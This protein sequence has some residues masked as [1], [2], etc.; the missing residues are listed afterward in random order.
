M[1]AINC[2]FSEL[3]TRLMKLQKQKFA[4]WPIV[5]MICMLSGSASDA[6][7]LMPDQPA[8][9][10]PVLIEEQYQQGHYAAAAQSARAY[11]A[12]PAQD[13]FKPLPAD[14]DK[15]N[16]Y[17]ALSLLKTDAP[18]CAEYARDVI[19]NTQNVAYSQRIAHSLAQ[20]YFMHDDLANAIPLYEASGI[21]NLDNKEIA[22]EKFELAYCYFNNKQFDKARPL[23]ASIKEIKDSR[24]YMAGNYYYGLLSY[25]ENRYTDALHSFEKVK[26]E[27]EYR[28][29]VPY[30][31]AEIYYFMGDR[32]RA[33]DLADSL[34]KNPEKSF[35]DKELHLLAAQCLFEMQKYKE[36]KPYF[37]FY[38]A[39]AD[40]IRKEELYEMAY[41][42]YR[43]DEWHN[44]IDKFKMLSNQQDSLGQT[45]MYLLG[46]CY[47]KTGD[48]ASARNAFGICAD[49]NFNKNQR[50]ASMILY[51]R[52]SY[53]MGHND[54]A[55][56]QLD[57]L[58]VV[59]PN[60]KYKDEANTLISGLLVKT[61]NYEDALKHLEMVRVKDKGYKQVYQQATFGFA[62]QLFRKGEKDSAYNYFSL[63]L[64]NAED[65]VYESAANFWKGELSYHLHH[66]EDV[67]TYSKNFLNKKSHIAAVEKI[68]P[69][70]TAQHAYLNMG[71]AAMELQDYIDAQSYFND[72]QNSA[73]EGDNYS[74]SV[75][76]L[77]EADAVFMQKN[78]SKAIGLYD[79][80]IA[81]GGADKD[82]ATYQ[83]SILL[84]LQGKNN[85]KIN[86]L[87][88]LTKGN[89]P[90]VYAS[91]ARYEIA[92]TY[93]EQDKYPQALSYL[94]TLIDSTG[95]KSLAP[96]AWMKIGFI[97][98]QSNELQKSIDAYKHVVSD[99]PA[100][101][102]RPAALDALKN[103]Y[104]QDNEPAGYTRLLR[105]N[106]LPSADSGML[107]STYYAA[108]ET[109]LSSG[110]N[111]EAKQ[112]FTNYL[113]QY[114]N[115]IFAI[116]A[117]YYRAECNFQLR[118]YAEAREDYET[119]LSY[120]WNDFSENSARRA[121]SISIDQKNYTAAF[122]YYR[123][124]RDHMEDN[125]SAEFV[126]NGLL[127]SSFYMDKNNEAILYADTLLGVPGI[128]AETSDA[129]QFYKAK[130]LQKAGK[131]DDAAALYKQLSGNK[132]GE[133]AAEARY[134]VAEIL[135]KQDKYKEA[136]DAAN[137]A[138]KLSA[139][140]EDWVGKSYLLLA[141]VLVKE[142][143]YFNA[144][145]LL[146]SIVKHTKIQELKQEATKKLDEVKKAE[147]GHSKLSEE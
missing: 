110:K 116:K 28:T 63:S 9:R 94:K 118:K 89:P 44:A 100:A 55:L 10:Y 82:Y 32:K 24:Y 84:G 61:S 112:G 81:A 98:Q 114:P 123:M 64:K 119:V 5:F 50:E 104:I 109:Q 106:N 14:V 125:S 86:L 51:S 8:N 36:A 105:D 69:L 23:F 132:N 117:H 75:A 134:R 37:E 78:Y 30:Y 143:D 126:F 142:K 41:T 128:S 12:P 39:H 29:I 147:K 3:K 138:I 141:D 40:K 99:Y 74:S 76:A 113:R 59:Y 11:M 67:I 108:A 107:D 65:P 145:A 79:K 80:I 66:Y 127:K 33:L 137:E 90:S 13:N 83:K 85:E 139:G 54:D 58:M 35:Y 103:L 102:E 91:N 62:V 45:S 18:G 2:H 135:L 101:E 20:Y 130:A 26:N 97:Y 42:Y 6:Q 122:K 70:A 46:D 52:L 131:A 34:I 1:R 95:D 53:E 19:A 43:I 56:R 21:D 31:I 17:L 16:Y 72:A 96:K 129:A 146:Q 38:Y 121:A 93:I 87:L 120:P 60:S 7:V 25:N 92:V 77:Q 57:T 47:L 111:E 48:K 88:T 27:K 136:E 4:A 124:L 49:L 133:V 22:D 73:K 144:K 115:G 68:S 140:Y 71:Y 15:A